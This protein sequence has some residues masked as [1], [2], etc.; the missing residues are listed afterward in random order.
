[1]IVLDKY[2][3]AG[4]RSWWTTPDQIPDDF[5]DSV[6]AVGIMAWSG[7]FLNKELMPLFV[8]DDGRIVRHPYDPKWCDPGRTSRDQIDCAIA[9]LYSVN[10]TDLCRKVLKA[11]A[12]RGFF[13]NKDILWFDSFCS[14]VLSASSRR[15]KYFLNVLFFPIYIFAIAWNCWITPNHEQN[16]IISRII[17]GGKIYLWIYTKLHPDYKKALKDYWN[18]WRMMPEL[19]DMMINKIEAL[20]KSGPLKSL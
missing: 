4:Q 18:G 12:K 20:I 6:R 14:L 1:M 7:S 9:G 10:R 16:Q 5:G 3:I 2:N 11:Y 13:C 8:R 17:V 19:S 15:A